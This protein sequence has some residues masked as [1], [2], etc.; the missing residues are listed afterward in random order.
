MSEQKGSLA[1]QRM[2]S[3]MAKPSPVPRVPQFRLGSGADH[4]QPMKNPMRLAQMILFIT[5]LSGTTANFLDKEMPGNLPL[6]RSDAFPITAEAHPQQP[7]DAWNSEHTEVYSEAEPL[8]TITSVDVTPRLRGV[9]H[10]TD[11]N[12]LQQSGQWLISIAWLI[13][14]LGVIMH[15]HNGNNMGPSRYCAIPDMDA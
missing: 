11:V 14:A 2:H 15:M 4:F 9:A 1:M 13:T 10:A 3:V 7:T 5:N 12:H 6:A 8:A